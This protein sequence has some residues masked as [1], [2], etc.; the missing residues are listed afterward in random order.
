MKATPH[1]PKDRRK[2][3]V[4]VMCLILC[5]LMVGGLMTSALLIIVSGASSSE[6]R[7][8]LKAL[9]EQAYEIAQQSAALEEKLE[10]NKSET[11]STIEKKTAI[12]QRIS[13][14]EA[15]IQ[16]TNEQIRQY[17]LLVAEKQSEV[18]ASE[19]DLAEMNAR[20][21]AR[22]RAMEENGKISYWSILFKAN[23]FSD[24][25]SRID[26]IREVAGVQMMDSGKALAI[27]A[28]VVFSILAIGVWLITAIGGWSIGELSIQD[29][30]LN[31]VFEEA[32]GL[33]N[34]IGSGM[35]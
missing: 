26:S 24:L 12:D 20:Y 8:E 23:S 16:N 15:E 13:I 27:N 14:T 21:K 29:V 6:I 25:L 18:E 9:E 33:L 7:K 35:F 1:K 11:Q 32:D 31:E 17:S 3:F 28:G 2:S 19:D 22:L 34:M 10:S 30:T 5:I 4:R